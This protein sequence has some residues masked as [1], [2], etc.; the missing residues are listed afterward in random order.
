MLNV[1]K[2]KVM[3]LS[4][5][6]NPVIHNYYLDNNLLNWV[7]ENLDLGITFSSNLTFNKYHRLSGRSL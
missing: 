1:D 3:T 5:S 7:V 2:C 4:R 6:R